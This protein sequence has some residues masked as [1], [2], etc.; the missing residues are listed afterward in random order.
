MLLGNLISYAEKV[1]QRIEDKGGDD[2][3][4]CVVAL[5]N[6]TTLKPKFEAS[7]SKIK[8][9][10]IEGNKKEPTNIRSGIN[11]KSSERI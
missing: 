2:N 6:L 9:N 3:D 4:P 5:K 7:L 10:S 1:L 11:Q 8:G